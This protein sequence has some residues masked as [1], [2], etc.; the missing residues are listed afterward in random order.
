MRARARVVIAMNS[1]SPAEAAAVAS[2]TG[3]LAK[4]VAGAASASHSPLARLGEA[5]AAAKVGARIVPALWRL[6]RRRPWSAGLGLLAVIAGVYLIAP[7]LR[8][9]QRYPAGER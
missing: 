2:D 3:A 7:R 6:V 5:A 4:N 9:I 8:S 1:S